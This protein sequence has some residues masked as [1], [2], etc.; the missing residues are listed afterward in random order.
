MSEKFNVWRTDVGDEAVTR[1]IEA[2]NAYEAAH[3][4][5]EEEYGRDDYESIEFEI[6][7]SDGRRFVAS[8]DAE[9]EPSFD[10]SCVRKKLERKKAAP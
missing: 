6:E 5:A 1:E 2:H 9:L 8:A 10:V 4:F 7:D 3:K